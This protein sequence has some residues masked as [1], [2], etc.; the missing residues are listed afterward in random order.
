VNSNLTADAG[1]WFWA[2]VFA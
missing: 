2:E 1:V